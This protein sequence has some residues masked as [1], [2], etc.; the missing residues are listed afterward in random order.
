MMSEKKSLT[1]KDICL[2]IKEGSKG[3]VAKLKFGDLE[4]SFGIEPEEPIVY[5]EIPLKEQEKIEQE[6]Q[7]KDR[8][9]SGEEAL[10]QLAIDDPVEWERQIAKG[11]LVEKQQT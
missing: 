5:T 6:I 10:S 9:E 2:I 3:G 1:A 11:E 4:I 7:L 8:V